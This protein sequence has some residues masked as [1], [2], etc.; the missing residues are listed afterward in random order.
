MNRELLETQWI[1]IREVIR[2]KFSSLTDEDIRQIN[3][4]YD[5]L[6]AKLQQKYGYTR[7][8]AEEKVRSW[9]Y[10]RLAT[11]QRGS[12]N[13]DYNSNV[14][15]DDWSLLKWILALGIPLL[16]LALYF[17]NP[18]RTDT[19]RS[20][21]DHREQAITETPADRAISTDLR[22]A[23]LARNISESDLRNI[24]ISTHN[25]VVTLSGTVPNREVRENVVNTTQKF[26]GVRQVINN[27]EIR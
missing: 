16:L 12:T 10:D 1:Q 11:S 20:P 3:G 19:T 15:R 26:T 5:Q 7:D 27:L 2:D 22:S 24:R 18:D 25:G 17:L 14:K 23:L 9:N 6:I 8:E 13:N 4:R 21:A